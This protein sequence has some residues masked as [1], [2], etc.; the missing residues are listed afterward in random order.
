[1]AEHTSKISAQTC[2]G[3]DPRGGRSLLLMRR[4]PLF[5]G[6]EHDVSNP[7]NSG[8]GD[9]YRDQGPKYVAI[10]DTR[11]QPRGVNEHVQPKP[12]HKH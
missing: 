6:D 2:E 11:Q 4:P 7:H 3:E 9:G 12:D 8:N 1:M 5:A 10:R